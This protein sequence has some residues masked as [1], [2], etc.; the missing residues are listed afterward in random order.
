[1]YVRTY[2]IACYV[3]IASAFAYTADPLLLQLCQL[4]TFA[5]TGSPGLGSGNGDSTTGAKQPSILQEGAEK[6]C[7][8]DKLRRKA[9]R[10]SY[11]SGKVLQPMQGNEMVM[12]MVFLVSVCFSKTCIGPLDLLQV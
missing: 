3:I 2:R 6:R 9:I 7:S 1:M 12:C 11:R 10:N 5:M 8:A 4:Q